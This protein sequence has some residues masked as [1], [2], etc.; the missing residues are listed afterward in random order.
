MQT[1]LMAG[2]EAQVIFRVLEGF[3]YAF[4]EQDSSG[5]FANKEEA[6]DMAY[7]MITLQTTMHNPSIRQKLTLKQIMEQAKVS[8]PESFKLA[9]MD[10][11]Y[12]ERVYTSIGEKTISSPLSRNFMESEYS[13]FEADFATIKLSNGKGRQMT[14]AEFLATGDLSMPGLFK[15]NNSFTPVEDSDALVAS[16]VR[17]ILGVITETYMAKGAENAEIYQRFL[18]LNRKI[19][20]LQYLDTI[21]RNIWKRGDCQDEKALVAEI[22]ANF[23][24][25]AKQTISLVPQILIGRYDSC[26]FGAIDQAYLLEIFQASERHCRNQVVRTQNQLQREVYKLEGKS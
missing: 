3:S 18:T 15:Y 9:K 23:D 13:R 16:A 7:L 19:G 10:E 14:V 21:L 22:M 2:V 12:V 20:N 1:F 26:A 8:C 24:K 5:I 6:Y 11:A 4:F 25:G 17:Q